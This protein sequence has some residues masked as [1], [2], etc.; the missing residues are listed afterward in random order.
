MS[1]DSR[2]GR[3]GHVSR[4]TRPGEDWEAWSGAKTREATLKN[5]WLPASSLEPK[6]E[7]CDGAA[8][9]GGVICFC[10]YVKLE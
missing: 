1:R 10:Q 8:E 5:R 7:A 6:D 3:P 9:E 4:A 2:P